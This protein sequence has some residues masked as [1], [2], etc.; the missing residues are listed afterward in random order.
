MR[1]VRAWR[2]AVG[3][4]AVA[5]TVATLSGQGQPAAPAAG[6]GG[7]RGQQTPEQAALQ[8]ARVG[9][10]TTQDLGGTATNL[11][12]FEPGNRTYWHSHEGGFIMFVQKGRGRVQR[13]GE[14]MKELGPGEVDY[15]PPG[16]EHWHGAT[17][18]DELL[19]LAVVVGG[20]GIQFKDPVS[21][22]EYQGKAK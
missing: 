8:A 19:Q 6:A 20:G 21:D 13:R 15:T 16:V 10:S 9:N 14:T 7:G 3:A 5:A 2:S 12:R 1:Q 22:T 4:L 17:P 11:R 18:S